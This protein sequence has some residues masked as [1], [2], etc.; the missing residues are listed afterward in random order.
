M[1]ASLGDVTRKLFGSVSE[2]PTLN[3]SPHRHLKAPVLHASLSPAKR[4][5]GR[6]CAAGDTG[7]PV[8]AYSRV[9]FFHTGT[10]L[11]VRF[12]RPGRNKVSLL[13]QTAEKITKYN[14]FI[15][16]RDEE[17]VSHPLPIDPW[18]VVESSKEYVGTEEEAHSVT[19]SAKT[20]SSIPTP[21]ACRG[22]AID[23]FHFDANAV[24]PSRSSPYF[25]GGEIKALSC[26]VT[27]PG[28]TVSKTR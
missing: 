19:I 2:N 21:R 18:R 4:P 16:K 26:Y 20:V 15:K 11:C 3:Q 6:P 7:G 9:I 13:G 5:A 22:P 14:Y 27:L 17:S 1:E 10:E 25:T 28:P 12:R 8:R 24:G 23:S